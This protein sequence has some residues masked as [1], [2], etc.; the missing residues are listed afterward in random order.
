MNSKEIRESFIAFFRERGHAVVPSS[1]LLP[2]DPSVLLTTAGMQQ[3]KRY[4]TGELNAAGDFGSR[5]A[6]SVQKCFRTSDIDEVGDETHLTFFEMLGNF[7]FGPVESDDPRDFGRGGYFKRAAI[8][9]AYEFTT[10]ILG[11]SPERL[12]ISVFEGDRDVPFDDDSYRIWN[13]EI[14][15]PK[16][17]MILGKRADNFWGPTGDE[18]PCGPTTEIY[19]ASTA[20]EA[21]AG[22]GVEIWNLVFN[23]YYREKD[24]RLRKLQNP[25]V[26]TGMGLER[27]TA[28]M[29]GVGSVFETDVFGDLL[30]KINELAPT[31]DDRAAR[32]FADHL[33]AAAFLIA[34][35]VRPSNK[36]AGYIL[37]RLLRR[38]F[39]Y[40]MKY[41][42]HADLFPDA[43][44][45]IKECFGAFYPE[46][47]DLKTLLEV[48]DEEQRKF[49]VAVGAGLKKLKDYENISGKDAFYLYETFGLPFELIKEMAPKAAAGLLRQDFDREFEKHQEISRAGLEKK[50]GGHG[51]IL[52]TGELKAGSEEELKKIVRLHTATHLMHQALR[53]TLGEEV[54]Q[55]GSDINTDRLRFDF[56][57][58]R[59]MTDEEKK[60]VEEIVNRKIAEDLPVGFS[61]LSKEEAEKTGALHFFKEKYPDRVKVYYIGHSL[62]DA[63]SKEFCGGPHVNHTLE[64]GKFRIIK[65]EAVGAGIRRIKATAE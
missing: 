28:V 57:F 7:S 29:G 58:P 21:V 8:F 46:L 54:K 9:W 17:R 45:I 59:K 47:N 12:T 61:E 27:L 24:G 32:V 55:A 41:D 31:L 11:I 20:A 4:F 39:A 63:F 64:V 48:A 10:G 42:V 43:F 49:G 1:S 3:F 65:E 33:R 26:D 37:R 6:V 44:R 53:E 34:D 52:N 60:K 5:R 35:G 18:G 36:E 40:R 19:V 50:F 23:E 22:K 56:L 51:L 13:E 14:G 15:I 25:G 2:D 16:N 30:A 62:N 38:L